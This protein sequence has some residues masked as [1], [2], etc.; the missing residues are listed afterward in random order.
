MTGS[1]QVTLD[2]TPP[3]ITWG[4][5]ADPVASEEMTVY[6]TLTE[7][8]VFEATITLLDGRTLPM[9]IYGDR[10]TVVLPDDAPEGDATVHVVLRDS[11]WNTAT[12]DLPVR[13]TGVVSPVGPPAPVGLPSPPTR[14]PTRS[15]DWG[16]S[17]AMASSDYSETAVWTSVTRLRVSSRYVTPTRASWTIRDRLTLSSSDSVTARVSTVETGKLSEDTTIR[18]RPLGPNAEAELIALGLL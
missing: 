9:Q 17:T 5:V 1:F 15:I 6:Y 3:A 2:T 8:S 14:A 10:L 18:K 7:P 16:D 11:V 13:V 4:A 12:S